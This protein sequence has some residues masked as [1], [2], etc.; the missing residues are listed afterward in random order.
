M[1]ER[2][3]EF[4]AAYQNAAYAARYRRMVERIR[5][6]ERDRVGGTRLAEAV[7]RYA[8]KL[9]AYKDEY[10]V[11]RLFTDG[12]FRAQVAAQFEGDYALHFHLAPPTLIRPDAASG[13]ATK[14]SFGPWMEWAMR[15][16]ARLRF[17]RGSAL[18]PF[19][20][21]AERREE[22]ALV[23]DYERLVEEMAERLDAA[24]HAAAIELARIPEQIRGYGHVKQRHLAAARAKQSEAMARWR[25]LAAA[26]TSEP[27]AA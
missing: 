5:S 13:V 26:P 16:L 8:F 6:V 2:R 11:A 7:A 23:G 1:V 3:A 27:I 18:D 15:G 14:R 10:E 20:R 19:G 25:A 17:L 24:H 22:R 21:T 12:T 4:L 9:M